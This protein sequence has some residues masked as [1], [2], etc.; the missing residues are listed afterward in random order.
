MLFGA[1]SQTLM[2]AFFYLFFFTSEGWWKTNKHRVYQKIYQSILENILCVLIPKQINPKSK[3]ME[4]RSNEMQHTVFQT[5]GS[6]RCH[7]H[8]FCSP[9]FVLT[10]SMN[11]CVSYHTTVGENPSRGNIYALR[12]CMHAYLHLHTLH[13]LQ[14][15]T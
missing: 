15:S 7:T 14:M 8:A 12:P 13:S 10:D 11:L 2:N 5:S 3:V 9:L 1:V 6:Y 4:I